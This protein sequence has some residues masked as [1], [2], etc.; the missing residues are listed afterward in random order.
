MCRA[1][2]KQTNDEAEE[3]A[4]HAETGAGREGAPAVILVKPQLGENIGTAARAMANFALH[5]LRLVAPRDGWPNA[6]AVKAAAGATRVL[7]EARLFDTVEAAIGDLH[8]VCATTARP[9][10]MI[11]PVMT[12]ESAAAEVV[13]RSSAGQHC[14]FLFG[15]E[16]AGLTNDDIALA[17]VIVSAPVNPEFASLNLAQSV[18]LVAYEW[19]KQDGAGGLGRKTAFDGPAREGLQMQ[20]TRPATRV[21]L[22]GFFEH[23]ER[24]LDA[25]GFLRPPEKRPV[26]VRNIR[27]LFHRTGATEQEVRTLRGIVSSLVKGRR[28]RE[29][30][31]K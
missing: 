3:R 4:R 1:M 16:K 2:R 29:S 25:S 19:L 5:D 8:F 15:A 22:T 13:S 7:E 6:D 17:D 27:N 23:L 10:D 9:R 21:E 31:Q 11:K 18:L 28:D 14:G 20:Q 26:M 24:E 30:R 12:P